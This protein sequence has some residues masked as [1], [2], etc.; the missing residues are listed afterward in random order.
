[1][2]FNVSKTVYM[3]FKPMISHYLICYYFPGFF[4]SGQ[5]LTFLHSLNIWG[6]LYAMTCVRMRISKEQSRFYSQGAKYFPV[7]LSDVRELSIRLFQTYC[8][9]LCGSALWTTCTS[10]TLQLSTVYIVFYQM[11]ES[12]LWVGGRPMPS[13]IVSQTCF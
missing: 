8:V 2:T 12:F 9:C 4:E 5:I 3:M 7:N 10:R 11:H 13:M 1:M 6:M